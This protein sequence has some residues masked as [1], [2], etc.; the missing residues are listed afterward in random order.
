MP[1]TPKMSFPRA[2][3]RGGSG[4]E[5][6]EQGMYGRVLWYTTGG[7]HGVD[8]SCVRRASGEIGSLPGA[9]Y[10]TRNPSGFRGFGAGGVQCSPPSVRSIVRSR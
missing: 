4:E 2:R 10:S 8:S 1:I 9:P 7:G 5:T 6:C 3:A